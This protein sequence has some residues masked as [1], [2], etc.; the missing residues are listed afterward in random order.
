MRQRNPQLLIIKG[1]TGSVGAIIIS[2]LEK[3]DTE[4]VRVNDHLG[5]GTVTESDVMLLKLQRLSS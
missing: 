5:V 3:L 4:D 2:S 1:D